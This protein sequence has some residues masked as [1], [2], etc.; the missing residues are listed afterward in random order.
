MYISQATNNPSAVTISG[1]SHSS[2]T[3]TSNGGS[4]YFYDHIANGVS[5]Y[6][7]VY[8]SIGTSTFAS[9]TCYGTGCSGAAIAFNAVE[10]VKLVLTST[11]FTSNNAGANG[12]VVF[13]DNTISQA[14]TLSLTSCT[15][16]SNVAKIS[17]GVI[18]VANTAAT[19][20]TTIA[21][22]TFAG[23]TSTN[24]DG[25]VIYVAGTVSNQITF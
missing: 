3:A 20:A 17:G 2:S 24:S 8:L 25:G 14:V 1:H 23:T 22:G 15:F 7:V 6:R 4:I 11:T 21:Q 18:Y 10:S 13:I 9:N 16:T 12:G 5:P 19:T